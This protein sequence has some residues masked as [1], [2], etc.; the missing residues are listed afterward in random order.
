MVPGWWGACQAAGGREVGEFGPESPGAVGAGAGFEGEAA[1][2]AGVPGLVAGPVGGSGFAAADVPVGDA[3]A[4]A[5]HCGDGGGLFPFVGGRELDVLVPFAAFD[6]RADVVLDEETP[7]V[8][9]LPDALVTADTLSELAVVGGDGDVG[10]VGGV[11]GGS[12]EGFGRDGLGCAGLG[13]EVQVVGLCLAGYVVEAFADVAGVYE[14]DLLVAAAGVVWLAV[15]AWVA[16][17]AA[18]AWKMP[19]VMV[20]ARAAVLSWW[21]VGGPFLR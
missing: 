2:L 21:F 19:A 13:G 12:F 17:A 7:V 14:E 16:A 9:G 3:H 15:M 10:D 20:A 1:W 6:R 11:A 4:R 8:A 5:V 18:R